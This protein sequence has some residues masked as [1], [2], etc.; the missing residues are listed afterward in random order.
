MDFFR[1]SLILFGEFFFAGSDHLL[2]NVLGA[3]CVVFK[4]HGKGSLALGCTAQAG[5]V[6]KHFRDGN[7]G[8]D[9]GSVIT[10][11]AARDD[12]P[13]AG[14]VADHTAL[15]FGRGF[16]FHTHH[17]FQNL[18]TSFAHGLFDGSAGTDAESHITGVDIVVF[19]VVQVDLDPYHREASQGAFDHHV[20]KACFTSTDVF[21][22][23]V[24]AL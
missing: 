1:G 18:G 20:F 24:A 16:H 15:E 21:G 7:R 11:L 8:H 23:N 17:G 10:N 6:A 14:E 13:T 22:R 12:P 4:F 5:A 19:P 9:H 3:G 2:L